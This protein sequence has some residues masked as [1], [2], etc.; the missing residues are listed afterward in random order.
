M[1]RNPRG[2][3]VCWEGHSEVVGKLVQERI[4]AGIELLDFRVNAPFLLLPHL[5]IYAAETLD[6]AH[7]TCEVGEVARGMVLHIV[8]IDRRPGNFEIYRVFGNG[9]IKAT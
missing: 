3:A 7:N 9:K 4:K 2:R 8:V 1:R 6:V 5:H